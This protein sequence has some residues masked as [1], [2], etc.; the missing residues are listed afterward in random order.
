MSTLDGTKKVGVAFRSPGYYYT[1]NHLTQG[2]QVFNDVTETDDN[3][4]TKVTE[5]AADRAI[6]AVLEGEVDC[7]VDNIHDF[8]K[9]IKKNKQATEKLVVTNLSERRKVVDMDEM[10]YLYNLGLVELHTP[11]LLGNI[12]DDRSPQVDPEPTTIGRCIFNRILP[13]EMRFVQDTMGKK[14][15]QDLVAKILSAGRS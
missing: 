1:Q 11:V 4:R 9:R 5:K 10:E 8:R 15:L 3:G 7:L 14:Q 12:Y 13:D 2:I 6:R